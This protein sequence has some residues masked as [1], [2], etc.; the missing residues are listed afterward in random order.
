M[1]TKSRISAALAAFTLVTAL[2]A[3][4]GEAQARPRF[5]L[6]LGI[7]LAAGTLIGAAGV[8]RSYAGSAYLVD[9]GYDECRFVDRYDRWGNVRTI[10]IC[11][12][13]PY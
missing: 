3:T 6:G 7:G 13:V 5:G 8:S 12:V 2:A 4:G 11:E 10:K 1:S 9:H